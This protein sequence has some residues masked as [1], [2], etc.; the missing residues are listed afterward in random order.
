MF[1]W[2]A[3]ATPFLHRPFEGDFRSSGFFDH[4]DPRRDNDRRQLATW[5]SWTWGR[6]GHAGYD[7]PM[8]VGTPVLAA[9]DGVVRVA[10]DHGPSRCGAKTVEKDVRLGILHTQDEVEVVSWYLHLSQLLVKEGDEVRAGQVVARSGNTGCSSGPHLHFG[11]QEGVGRAMV[12]PY[13]WSGVGPDPVVGRRT[14]RWLWLPG[15]APLLQR[16][17]TSRRAPRGRIGVHQVRSVAWG[18][19]QDPNQEWTELRSRERVQLEGFSLQN[20][21]GDAVVLPRAVLKPS[22]P[23]RLYSGTGKASRRFGYAGRESDLWDDRGDCAFL[24][25]PAGAIVHRLLLGPPHKGLCR[26]GP[27]ADASRRGD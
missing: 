16:I 21:A 18:A 13:G 7:W 22:R 2:A 27:G 25:D 24:V 20:R 17:E 1:C 11:V 3:L 10:A 26:E 4:G 8:P 12:D 15:E 23:W 5:G 14:S 19:T 6:R 9:A